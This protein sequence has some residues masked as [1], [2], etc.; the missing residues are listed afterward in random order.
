MVGEHPEGGPDEPGDPVRVVARPPSF[1]EAAQGR[2]G[3][4]P[5]AQRLRSVGQE[6]ELAGQDIQAVDTRSALAR[7]L[8]F[9]VAG[10]PG[11]LHQRADPGGQQDD[12]AG[13][14]RRARCTGSL[15]F[16]RERESRRRGEPP[17]PVPTEQ[18]RLDPGGPLRGDPEGVAEG[19]PERHLDDPRRLPQ[20]GHRDQCRTG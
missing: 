19:R 1:D 12:H 13:T 8:A 5:T 15:F 10:D 7:S 18:H 9:H 16:E 6:L 3:G 14:D 4:Q 17:T 11:D 2:E 20:P